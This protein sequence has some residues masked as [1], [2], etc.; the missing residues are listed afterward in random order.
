M[1]RTM[2]NARGT[3]A[4]LS[5]PSYRLW[6]FGQMTSL[7][8][9]WMQS[10]AQGYLVYELTHSAAYLGYVSFASGI[11]MWVF[12]LYG[13]VVAD[14]VPRRSL[15]VVTQGLSML[16]A[17]VLSALTFT[18]VV[19]PWHILGLAFLLGAVN[20]FDV[21][22]RQSFVIE[23][24]GRDDLTNAI[25][26][27]SMM[28]NAAVVAGPAIGGVT[29]ALFG[30][31][32]CF[33]INGVSFVAVIAALLAMRLAPLAQPVRRS[34]A[35]SEIREGLRVVAGD[36]GILALVALM[37]ALSL[38]GMSYVTLMPAWAVRVLHGDARTNGFLQS[39]RGLG[40]LAAAFGIASLGRFRFRGR[41]LA[42]GSILFPA[43]LVLF[44]FTHA[45]PLSLL[46]LLLVGAA[47][48]S[49]NSLANSLVQTRTP[50]A[51]RGRVMSI[52]NLFFMGL[53]PIGSLLA[54]AIA[55][56]GGAPL[57]VRIGAGGTLACAVAIQIAA[58]SLR[59]AE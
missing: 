39:A 1:A 12:T 30:P 51:V 21:P 7:F 4:A 33:A 15:L 16:L 32:W 17:L 10:A 44:S 48:I 11:A 9:T 26:L 19:A 3:F 27:N 57:A 50:D 41:L 53:I 8:G 20:A 49:I 13:G 5:Y 47:N 35:L 6:F 42:A 55:E 43:A 52:Y 24:V 38:F 40:A 45:L 58:P 34:S 25:A 56:K 2:N 36:R 37:G 31:G 14:R 23:M 46:A 18:R 29:Y 59:K 22:A 54:G 28:F